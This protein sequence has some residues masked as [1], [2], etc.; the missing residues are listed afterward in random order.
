MQIANCWFKS[1]VIQVPIT[2]TEGGVIICLLFKRLCLVNSR[3]AVKMGFVDRLLRINGQ[4]GL[5]TPSAEELELLKSL[6]VPKLS[7]Q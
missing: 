1:K 7:A 3:Q 4:G 5:T 2:V 6:K